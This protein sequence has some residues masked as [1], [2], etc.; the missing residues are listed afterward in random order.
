M[1]PHHLYLLSS[2]RG[3]ENSKKQLF[4]ASISDNA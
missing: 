2:E 3:E 4:K 1:W